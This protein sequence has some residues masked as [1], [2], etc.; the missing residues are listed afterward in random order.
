MK[1]INLITV[2]INGKETGSIGVADVKGYMGRMWPGV[3]YKVSKDGKTVDMTATPEKFM[4]VRSQ[5]FKY[6]IIND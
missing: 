4:E 2:N 5:R 3:S 6:H 1:D